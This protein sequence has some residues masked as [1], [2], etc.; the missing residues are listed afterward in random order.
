MLDN[1]NNHL[2]NN[3]KLGEVEVPSTCTPTTW[4]LEE[5]EEGWELLTRV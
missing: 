4:V 5:G 1:I 3:M 2:S